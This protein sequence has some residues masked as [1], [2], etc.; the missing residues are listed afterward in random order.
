MK[1]ILKQGQRVLFQGDSVTDCGRIREDIT[2]LGDGYPK[3]IAEIVNW[4]Y[5]E[6][7]ITFINKG[8]SGN[9]VTDLLDRYEE[10]FKNIKP[11][12][13]SILIGINDTWRRY[14][15]NDPTSTEQFEKNYRTLLSKVKTD[16]PDCKIMLI[17]PFVLYSV[18]GRKL[19]RED[20]DPKIH[21]VR[22]LAKEF[23]D[24]YLPM[25]GIFSKAE[26][27]CCSCTQIA[28]DGV[29]PTQIGHSIIAKEYLKALGAI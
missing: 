18:E 15:S 6:N 10:D 7:E 3:R 5:P 29:H 17:E 25:D 22:A 1:G 13:L 19:W 14:D 16:L 27:E 28:A 12:F 9:R 4:L 24:F 8:I 2:D 21:V 23:A 26:V 11:D 20:L